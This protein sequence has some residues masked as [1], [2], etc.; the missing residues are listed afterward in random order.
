MDVEQF[1]DPVGN[2]HAHEPRGN[3]ERRVLL[4]ERSSPFPPNN[5]K[6]RYDNES[7]LVTFIPVVRNESLCFHKQRV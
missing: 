4:K 5:E 2:Q 3:H 7:D 6:G 1:D